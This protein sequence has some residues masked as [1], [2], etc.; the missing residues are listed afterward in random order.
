MHVL[1]LDPV[2]SHGDRTCLMRL[3]PTPD[4]KRWICLDCGIDIMW[5]HLNVI[6]A[7]EELQAYKIDERT[8]KKLNAQADIRNQIDREQGVKFIAALIGDQE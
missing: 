6:E 5:T 1:V 8:A 3:S 4:H 2:R 7:D